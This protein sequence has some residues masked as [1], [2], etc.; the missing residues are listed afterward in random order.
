MPS[1]EGDIAVP[2]ETVQYASIQSTSPTEVQVCWS[3]QAPHVQLHVQRE[4]V[5]EMRCPNG[6]DDRNRHAGPNDAKWGCSDCPP[7]SDPVPIGS[8]RASDDGHLARK[9]SSYLDGP[10]QWAIWRREG[11]A[12]EVVLE[13]QLLGWRLVWVPEDGLVPADI[14]TEPFDRS[15]LNKMIR[16][17]RKARDDAYGADA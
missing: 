2:R 9:I 3:K 15:A 17:L 5:T 12:D 13:E 1:I 16:M 7:H 10:D 4:V 6:C 8:I 14:Y 11:T